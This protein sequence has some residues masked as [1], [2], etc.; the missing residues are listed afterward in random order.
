[1]SVLTQKSILARMEATELN[2]KL[3]ITPLLD[4]DKQVKE[5]S[6]DLRLGSRFLVFRRSEIARI[7]A[8]EKER[9][10]NLSGSLDRVTKRIDEIFTLHPRQFALGSTFEYIHLPDDLCAYVTSRSRYG[11]LGL[12]IATAIFVHPWWRGCLTL[13]LYNVGEVPVELKCGAR[14]AN[15]I[16]HEAIPLEV[17]PSAHSRLPTGPVPYKE[18]KDALTEVIIP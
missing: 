7:S 5:G 3:I 16:L 2:K 13:E 12:V 9:L 14:I 4:V 11:R 18:D 10:V 1:M 8:N 6:V 17:P 15:L